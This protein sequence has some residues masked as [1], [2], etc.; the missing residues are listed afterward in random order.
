MILFRIVTAMLRSY[1]AKLSTSTTV[2]RG[3]TGQFRYLTPGSFFDRFRSELIWAWCAFG[4]G[5][6][7]AIERDQ[8]V[9][10]PLVYV[11]HSA[12]GYRDAWDKN[13]EKINGSQRPDAQNVR[14][15]TAH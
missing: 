5:E 1:A 11:M 15:Q 3:K 12:N 14:D 9:P 10:S 6:N 4:D 7:E 8:Q 13:G 2:F